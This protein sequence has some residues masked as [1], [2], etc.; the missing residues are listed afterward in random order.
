MS[1]QKTD[2][3]TFAIDLSTVEESNLFLRALWAEIR[4]EFG[5]LAW[6]YTPAL[7]AKHR[8]IHLGFMSTKE[9]SSYGVTVTYRKRGCIYDLMFS[10]VFN[11]EPPPNELRP[12]VS[13]ALENFREPKTAWFKSLLA[14]QNKELALNSY[15]SEYWSLC[16]PYKGCIETRLLVD[17]FD[18]EDGV[19]EFNRIIG[20]VLDQI[21]AWTNCV[22]ER[23]KSF[24]FEDFDKLSDVEPNKFWANDDWID[25]LPFVAGR[26][27]LSRE[28]ALALNEYMGKRLLKNDPLV[29]ACR[30]FR[31]GLEL[32]RAYRTGKFDASGPLVN[33]LFMSALEV[34]S[35]Q[36]APALERCV[37]CGQLKHKISARVRKLGEKNFGDTWQRLFGRNYGDRSSFLHE[38]VVKHDYPHYGVSFPQLDPHSNTGCAMPSSP[39]DSFNLREFCSF[40][41]RV[42]Y[43]RWANTLGT[44]YGS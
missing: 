10:S 2:H 36:E 37:E 6:Q 35:L 17:C 4:R 18:E 7:D 20:P 14:L 27:S 26:V 15:A 9:N 13:K 30:H 40:A 42:E 19:F 12:C 39:M 34:L 21:S 23:A 31:E 33:T 41:I 8:Q 16:S 38:G 29:R 22:I 25:G 32:L 44:P 28:H 11:P 5:R 43:R 3:L 24:E 1:G